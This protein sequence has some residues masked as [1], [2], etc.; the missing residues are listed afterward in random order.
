MNYSNQVAT[1]LDGVAHSGDA[2]PR[3]GSRP[4]RRYGQAYS[5]QFP[6]SIRYGEADHVH[7]LPGLVP[8][9]ALADFVNALK[10]GTRR[11]VRNE[12]SNPPASIYDKPVLWRRSDCILNCGGAPPDII[13][14]T[15]EQQTTPAD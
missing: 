13:Q 4:D 5:A 9:A 14:P 6:N 3:R 8:T 10:P 12:F 15:I 7:L 1:P 2:L 11:R